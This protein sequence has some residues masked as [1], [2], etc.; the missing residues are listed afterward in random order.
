MFV[1][2]NQQIAGTGK[3]RCYRDARRR[4]RES[5]TEC[6]G[7]LLSHRKPQINEEA[8]AQRRQGCLQSRNAPGK[9]SDSDHS[10]KGVERYQT[11]D[12]ESS[13]EASAHNVC[14]FKRLMTMSMSQMAMNC[15]T[16]RD[17][18]AGEGEASKQE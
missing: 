9:Y 10:K 11:A 16:L 4:E 18:S 7:K 3:Y 15:H 13:K 1:T 2:R 17:G 5:P 6:F 14:D 12:C 8:K